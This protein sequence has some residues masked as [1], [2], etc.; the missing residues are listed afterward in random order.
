MS[1]FGKSVFSSVSDAKS[2]QTECRATRAC[3]QEL[4]WGAAWLH[5]R[6]SQCKP[7]AELENSFSKAMLRCSL[8]S[9]LQRYNTYTPKSNFLSHLISHLQSYPHPQMDVQAFIYRHSGAFS[10]HSKKWNRDTFFYLLGFIQAKHYSNFIV[11]L[12]CKVLNN[13]DWMK[14]GV[15]G[16]DT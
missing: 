10:T 7:N 8:T 1:K 11:V 14:Y 4:C 9:L 6:Q 5:R 12:D 13:E 16:M 2:V 15:D 3:S